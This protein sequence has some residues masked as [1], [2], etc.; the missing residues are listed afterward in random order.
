MAPHTPHPGARRRSARRPRAREPRS[1]GDGWRRVV[2]S[3][4]CD[5]IGNCPVCQ[6]DY[7]ECACPGPTMDDEYEY[8][9]F[10]GALWAKLLTPGA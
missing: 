1:P 9:E 6:I 10:D 7:S 2:F 4:E 8:R 5:S 3:A